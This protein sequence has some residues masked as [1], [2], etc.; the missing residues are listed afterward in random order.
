MP[1]KPA[2]APYGSACDLPT[3][4]ELEKQIAAFEA[5]RF[6][7]PRKKRVERAKNEAANKHS[8]AIKI[9]YVKSTPENWNV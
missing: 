7:L 1:D 4:V 9:N 2:D 6:L 8:F 3:A 5:F